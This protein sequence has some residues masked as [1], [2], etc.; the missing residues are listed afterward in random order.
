VGLIAINDYIKCNCDLLLTLHNDCVPLLCRNSLVSE[1]E[2]D[3][4][5]TLST[6]LSF[7]IQRQLRGLKSRNMTKIAA[8]VCV[9]FILLHLWIFVGPNA[10]CFLTLSVKLINS[11]KILINTL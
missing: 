8:E 9:T 4:M 7:T 5:M 6:L 11:N 10:C 2:I 1:S 3:D